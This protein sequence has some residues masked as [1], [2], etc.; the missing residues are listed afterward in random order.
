MTKLCV[1]F[2][3][4]GPVKREVIGTDGPVGAGGSRNLRANIAARHLFFPIGCAA[5]ETLNA[6]FAKCT[7]G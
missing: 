6:G 1:P 3:L 7:L 4:L 2:V 5:I